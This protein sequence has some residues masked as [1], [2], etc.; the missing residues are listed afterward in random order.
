VNIAKSDEAFETWIGKEC[1]TPDKLAAYKELHFIPTV[2]L[3]YEDFPTF[4][5]EREKILRVK[6]ANILDVRLSE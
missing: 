5:E 1:P 6:L 4:L 3:K 2:S